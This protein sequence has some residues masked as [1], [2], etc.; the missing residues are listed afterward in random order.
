[1]A[2]ISSIVEPRNEKRSVGFNCSHVAL[3]HQEQQALIADLQTTV[4]AATEVG[5]ERGVGILITAAIAGHRRRPRMTAALDHEETRLP[6]SSVLVTYQRQLDQVVA[7]F[8]RSHLP[9][10]PSAALEQRARTIRVIAQS[11]IDAHENAPRPEFDQA[12]TEATRAV[13]VT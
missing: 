7:G 12:R 6:I 1:V 3:I 10:H 13:I 2:R 5:L 11:V 8:L 4:A 9:E